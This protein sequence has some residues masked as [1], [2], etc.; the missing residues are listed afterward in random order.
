M[1]APPPPRAFVTRVLL[2]SVE[3]REN[4]DDVH[5]PAAAP[6]HSKQPQ[7]STG[8][9]NLGRCCP[10][11]YYTESPLDSTGQQEARMRGRSRPRRCSQRWPACFKGLTRSDHSWGTLLGVSCSSVSVASPSG[12]VPTCH[13]KASCCGKRACSSSGGLQGEWTG[14]VVSYRVLLR[15]DERAFV[16]GPASLLPLLQLGLAAMTSAGQLVLLMSETVESRSQQQTPRSSS[17]GGSAAG[18]GSGSAEQA[19]KAASRLRS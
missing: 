11:S 19:A 17:S 3:V 9:G 12:C 15:A 10:F 7:G 5:L 6:F 14:T 8:L 16:G 2:D 1:T 18:R 4:Q 13:V